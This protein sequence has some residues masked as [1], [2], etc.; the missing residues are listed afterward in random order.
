M[1]PARDDVGSSISTKTRSGKDS[2]TE[3]SLLESAIA[4]QA[5]LASQVRGVLV[6]MQ[7]KWKAILPRL[8]FSPNSH[9][10]IP[11]HCTGAVNIVLIS[12]EVLCLAKT[13]TKSGESVKQPTYEC[14]WFLAGAWR[15]IFISRNSLTMLRWKTLTGTSPCESPCWPWMQ[16]GF[17]YLLLLP[18]CGSAACVRARLFNETDCARGSQPYPRRSL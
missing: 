15:S 2:L 16:E 12:R 5:L 9:K 6:S 11:S 14:L 17:Q 3:T 1:T 8:S 4:L 7:W 18:T 10:L 13:I